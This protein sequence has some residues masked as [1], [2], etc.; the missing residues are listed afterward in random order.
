MNWD[1]IG[2]VAEVLGATGV[3]ASLIY[4][5][6]QIR[7]SR[8]QMSQNTQALRAGAYQQLHEYIGDS[9]TTVPKADMEIVRLGL[10][11]FKNLNEADAF[12]FSFWATRFVPVPEDLDIIWWSTSWP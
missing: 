3:I 1:A 8:E 12:R 11:S 6:T 2:A 9:V 10:Q 4:L 5:A 7:Q